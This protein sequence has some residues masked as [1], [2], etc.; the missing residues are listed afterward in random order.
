MNYEYKCGNE[1]MLHDVL[2][3]MVLLICAHD[4]IHFKHVNNS[5]H[6]SLVGFERLN[7]MTHLEYLDLS[8]NSFS[9]NILSSLYGL[10]SLKSLD[11]NM[12]WLGPTIY[13]E[14]NNF[15]LFPL[16][17]L[18]LQTKVSAQYS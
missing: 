4:L 15:D 14:D 3:F 7:R 2:Y 12:N 10:S 9:D 17:F 18:S 13:F 6:F 5:L 1:N 8:G 16:I 11:I